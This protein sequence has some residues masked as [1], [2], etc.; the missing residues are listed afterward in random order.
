MFKA[1]VHFG[2]ASI[3]CIGLFVS[4]LVL[5]TPHSSQ[6]QI[7]ADV[8]VII[9]KLPLDKQE[10]MRGFDK[11]VEQYIETANWFEEDD[12][13]PMEIS[14]QLFLTDSPS[15][16]EDRYNCEFLISG[17][18]VQYFDKRVRFPYQPG[19]PLV[20]S[21]QSADPLTSVVDFYVNIVIGNELDKTRSFG[22]DFYFK[23]AQSIAALGKFVR[24]EFIRG[25]T[26]R[27]ELIKRL[28]SEPFTT[29]R[30][31]KDYYFYG[32][33]MRE[34]DE[35]EARKNIRIAFD[36]LET[37]IEKK[38]NLDEPKQFLN[39]HYLEFIEI[40]KNDKNKDEVFK[41]LMKLDPAHEEL[42]EE[43][44]SDS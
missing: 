1:R 42:Y 23:R 11:V 9:D 8:Q 25:W 38:A 36:L 31:M 15:N 27:E 10:K 14:L 29:F 34:E 40:F 37:V 39:A 7:K 6:G 33:Y 41:K 35:A 18:D 32:L 3:L 2:R 21:E 20:Y 17:S 26:Q 19:D 22:G 13:I 43:H 44:V 12:E 28:L 24:T 4:G 5:S 16:V 30:R